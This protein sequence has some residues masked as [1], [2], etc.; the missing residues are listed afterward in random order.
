MTKEPATSSFTVSVPIEVRR[1]G[2]QK[3]V[4]LTGSVKPASGNVAARP[5]RK[6]LLALARALRWQRQLDA[7]VRATMA[8]I[9][10]AEDITAS[11]VAR[12]LRML[13]L[14]PRIVD[15]VVW[16]DAL[17]DRIVD[18]LQM[19]PE[20]LWSAQIERVRTSLRSKRT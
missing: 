19:A 1:R 9:A 15:T 16:T 10:E 2:G 18:D 6:V 17:K 20:A 3:L 14:A 12:N 8:E 11:F 13:L 7:G 5:D 4:V